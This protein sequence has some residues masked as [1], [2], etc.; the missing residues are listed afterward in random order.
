M[1][2]APRSFK[3]ADLLLIQHGVHMVGQIYSRM[4]QVAD[5]HDAIRAAAAA[6]PLFIL[7]SI[8]PDLM[9]ERVVEYG[10]LAYPPL[11][12]LLTAPDAA[13]FWDL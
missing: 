7:V 3:I 1:L 6:T 11:A 2:A 4:P 13:A 9:F 5:E 12:H 8:V 10:S